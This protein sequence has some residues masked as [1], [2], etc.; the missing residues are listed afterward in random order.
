MSLNDFK[1]PS[2]T[3]AATFIQKVEQLLH[4]HGHE[5]RRML[6]GKLVAPQSGG[7]LFRVGGHHGDHFASYLELFEG[8]TE[9]VAIV[10]PHRIVGGLAT[11]THVARYMVVCAKLQTGMRY[12]AMFDGKPFEW[13]VPNHPLVDGIKRTLR[14]YQQ[15][16]VQ[17]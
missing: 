9:P 13:L 17:L 6:E 12:G 4:D 7:L 14:E 3:L 1:S 5:M 2:E 15:E 10:F 16:G 8:M 11:D